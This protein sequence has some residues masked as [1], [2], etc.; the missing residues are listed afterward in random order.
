MV[1]P[2]VS[3]NVTRLACA[4]RSFG[5]DSVSVAVRVAVGARSTLL[6][7][8]RFG[9]C[10]GNWASAG[11]GIASTATASSARMAYGVMRGDGMGLHQRSKGP[12]SS[13]CRECQVVVGAHRV[14]DVVPRGRLDHGPVVLG[15]PG[16]IVDVPG[17]QRARREPPHPEEAQ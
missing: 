11:A 1:P 16:R 4:T 6:P 5:S 7:V 8:L 3:P 12:R 10:C 14:D 13:P 15:D 2:A 9:A 17:P